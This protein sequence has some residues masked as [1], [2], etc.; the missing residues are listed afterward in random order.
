MLHLILLRN[1]T[2][3][4]TLI[5]QFLVPSHEAEYPMF[6]FSEGRSRDVMKLNRFRI[7]DDTVRCSDVKDESDDEL[8]SEEFVFL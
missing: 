7:S 2:K 8:E 5:F 1:L 3:C 4:S 6:V